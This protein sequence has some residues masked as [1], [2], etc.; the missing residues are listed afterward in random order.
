MGSAA[1]KKAARGEAKLWCTQT[2]VCFALVLAAMLATVAMMARS[3]SNHASGLSTLGAL[4]RRVTSRIL[5]AVST[6]ADASSPDIEELDD[7]L[8]HD[9]SLWGAYRR[10][11]MDAYLAERAKCDEPGHPGWRSVDMDAEGIKNY[12]SYQQSP[13]S[14]KEMRPAG[15]KVCDVEDE[16]NQSGWTFTRFGPLVGTGG[17]DWHEGN[18]QPVQRHPKSKFITAKMFA[19]VTAN[20]TILNYPP[21]HAHHVHYQLEGIQHWFDSH[22]DSVC[23]EEQ[24]GTA[25]YLREEPEGYG[26]PLLDTSSWQLDFILNDVRKEGSPPMTFY[27]ETSLRWSSDTTLKPNARAHYER[28]PTTHVYN[29]ILLP[30]REESIMWHSGKWFVPGQVI[31]SPKDQYPWL[32][33]HRSF[34]KGMWAFAASPEELGLTPDLLELTPQS[35]VPE[36]SSELATERDACWVPRDGDMSAEEAMW[37]VIRNSEAGKEAARCWLTTNDDLADKRTLDFVPGTDANWRDGYVEAWQQGWEESWYDRAGQVY[38]NQPW[39]FEPGDNYT[40]IAVN[41]LDPRLDEDGGWDKPNLQHVGFKLAYETFADA[42]GPNLEVY[43]S[44]FD[45]WEAYGRQVPSLYKVASS[46]LGD[47]TGVAAGNQEDQ[48][49]ES[50]MVRRGHFKDWYEH[51]YNETGVMDE[52]RLKANERIR[53]TEYNVTTGYVRF[54]RAPYNSP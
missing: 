1:L 19:P 51:H 32:H 44:F 35:A 47:F 22:G 33:S 36:G 6:K 25:C 24:G 46:F 38:C 48:E 20:G 14:R 28:H 30:L 43:S 52:L 17:Y 10:E 41:G 21:V 49:E 9:P 4:P 5:Q 39:L 16:A 7:A 11:S 29:T 2:K 13:K 23:T 45:G 50:W 42:P 40:I 27:M 3:R 31:Y 8:L 15:W 54:G 34:L 12:Y 53:G 18:I 26:L 37:H